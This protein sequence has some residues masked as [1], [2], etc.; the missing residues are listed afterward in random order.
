M[1]I[2]S[3]Y[4]LIQI[5]LAVRLLRHCEKNYPP[6]HIVTHIDM[7]LKQLEKVGFQVSLAGSTELKKINDELKESKEEIAGEDKVI[8]LNREMDLM[9]RV[10]Y[11]EAITKKVY[12]LP[13]RRFNSDSLLKNPKNVLKEGVVEKL[14]DMAKFDV[15]SGCRCILFGEATASVFHILRATE[16]TLKQYYFHHKKQNR[17]E[18]PMWGDMTIELR[19]K[20]R[21][22]PPQVILDSLDLV[23]ISYR[24]PTQHPDAKYD[25]DGA[26]D[27][28]GVCVDLIN[29]MAG[30]L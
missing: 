23:R 26:Q 15:K 2:S 24:N 22:K 6:L 19:K 20:H 5:G 8:Q 30:E 18:K 10:I 27:I 9:E 17:L 11:S 29:K 3:S 7:L 16:D 14:S 25:I 21:N 4:E 13:E 28:L 12:T 1:K